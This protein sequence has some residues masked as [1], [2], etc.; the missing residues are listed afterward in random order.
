M[1]G[2]PLRYGW[3]VWTRRE[4]AHFG[5]PAQPF[6]DVAT[7]GTPTYM[8]LGRN[9]IVVPLSRDQYQ[10]VVGDGVCATLGMAS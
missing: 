5:M 1:C 9:C 4:T 6:G 8:L 7:T 10:R 2:R 3:P